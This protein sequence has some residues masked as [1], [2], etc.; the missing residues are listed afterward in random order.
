MKIWMICG[1]GIE[2]S[3]VEKMTEKAKGMLKKA[4]V[5]VEVYRRSD[6]AYTFGGDGKRTLYAKGEFVSA[7]DKMFLYGHFDAALEGIEDALTAMGTQSINRMEAKRIAGSKLKSGQILASGDLPVAKTLPIFRNTPRELLIHEFG[8]PL[9][10]KPDGGYGGEG[11]KLIKSE[12]EL[13]KYLSGL[14]EKPDAVFLAQEY[15][16]SSKGKDIRVLIFGGK[17]YAAFERRTSDPEEFRSNVHL[18]GSIEKVELTEDMAA[19]CEKAARLI[20]LNICGIDLLFKEEGFII[21]EINDSPGGLHERV[22]KS[23]IQRVLRDIMA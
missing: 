17:T 11:V 6:I 2:T 12:E 5:E 20:G 14:P 10:V 16:E 23:D 8:I 13:E 9:I 7:P 22:A 1:A 19:L 18:G 15:I 4:G 21:G 3:L